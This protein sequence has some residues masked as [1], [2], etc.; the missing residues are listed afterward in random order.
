MKKEY[1]PLDPMYKNGLEKDT[2]RQIKRIKQIDTRGFNRWQDQTLN[3]AEESY[4][5]FEN[6]LR[7]EEPYSQKVV[8]L[9][10]EIY[11][12]LF[13]AAKTMSD[14][15]RYRAFPT[16]FWK[17]EAEKHVLKHNFYESLKAKSTKTRKISKLLLKS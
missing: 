8:D 16:T 6:L 15:N 7:K 17:T 1:N 9:I 10:E 13:L 14:S 5:K 2:A 3:K 11:P 4:L 12:K